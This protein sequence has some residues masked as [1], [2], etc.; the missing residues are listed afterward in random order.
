MPTRRALI[1]AAV[2]IIVGAAL[3]SHY[4]FLE[5]IVLK[6]LIA[7]SLA[8]LAFSV[9]MSRWKTLHQSYKDSLTYAVVVAILCGFAY[10]S[11]ASNKH[12]NQ[13]YFARL[14]RIVNAHTNPGQGWEERLWL[15]RRCADEL[16]ERHVRE[17]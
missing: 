10:E 2:L 3:R 15:P 5:Q 12:K 14:A 17:L 7:F 6:M 4:F 8:V 1:I 9:L 16:P 11:A 13:Q